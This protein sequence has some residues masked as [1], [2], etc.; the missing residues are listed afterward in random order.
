MRSASTYH[1]TYYDCTYHGCTYYGYT[2]HGCTY[3]SLGAQGGAQGSRS[4]AG[5]CEG[6]GQ[7]VAAAAGRGDTQGGAGGGVAGGTAG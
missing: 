5:R 7:H 3:T 4:Q 1:Y 2:Y 6:G